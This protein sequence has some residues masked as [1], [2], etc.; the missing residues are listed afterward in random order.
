MTALRRGLSQGYVWRGPLGLLTL[1]PEVLRWAPTGADVGP[2]SQ[3]TDELRSGTCLSSAPG[4][5]WAEVLRWEDTALCPDPAA[6]TP[7]LRGSPGAPAQSAFSCPVS[8]FPRVPASTGSGSATAWVSVPAPHTGQGSPSPRGPV[9]RQ[10][11]GP[12]SLPHQ[13]VRAPRYL[14]P[15]PSEEKTRK[16]FRSG[17]QEVTAVS[18]PPTSTAK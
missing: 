10:H 8:G 17:W 13:M 6:G 3:A 7:E 18:P 5:D 15:G 16:G 11:P 14:N 12:H 1:T 4:G 2:G 9:T